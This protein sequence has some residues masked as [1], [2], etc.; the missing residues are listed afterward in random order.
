MVEDAW[1]L[2]AVGLGMN[3]KLAKVIGQVIVVV[4][5]YIF[6]KLFIFKKEKQNEQ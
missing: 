1:L 5:N 4:I 6:S 3:D 2:A